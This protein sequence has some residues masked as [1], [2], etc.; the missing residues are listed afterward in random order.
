V[1]APSVESIERNYV[2]SKLP[3]QAD[4]YSLDARNAVERFQNLRMADSP[5]VREANLAHHHHSSQALSSSP[6]KNRSSGYRAPIG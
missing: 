5:D 4:R 3:G 1:G 6:L 2:Y